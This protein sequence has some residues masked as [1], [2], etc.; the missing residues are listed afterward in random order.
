MAEFKRIAAT[1]DISFYQF[2]KSVHR[3]GEICY[4]HFG[5][6]LEAVFCPH[7]QETQFHRQPVFAQLQEFR[8]KNPS[9]GFQKYFLNLSRQNSSQTERFT[10]LKL[11][12]ALFS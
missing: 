9:S 7:I 2:R 11:I 8:N 1:V 6:N 12:S 4:Y 10:T 3:K 5:K